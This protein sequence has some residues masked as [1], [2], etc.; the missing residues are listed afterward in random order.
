MR[1]CISVDNGFTTIKSLNPSEPL[2]SDAASNI[3]NSPE[4]SFDA[5]ATLKEVL[6]R[7]SI[8]A[9]NRG[10]LIGMLLLTLARDQVIS[11]ELD[12]CHRGFFNVIDFLKYLF[13][14]GA[15]Q[16]SNFDDILEATPS[17]FQ[18]TAQKTE[19]L[20]DAFAEIY[21]HFN[22]FVKCRA[23][24][25]LDHRLRAG[26]F[27]RNAAVTCANSLPGIDCGLPINRGMQVIQTST[28]FILFQFKNDDSY[29]AAIESHLF[30]MMDPVDLGIITSDEIL[31]VPIIRIVFALA[32]RTPALRYVQ[33]Q[34]EGKFT[35]YDI[36]A[37]G[38]TGRVFSIIGEHI[39]NWQALLDASHGWETIYRSLDKATV[40]IKKTMTPMA[41]R[42]DVFWQWLEPGTAG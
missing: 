6:L 9:G 1:V 31:T 39:E 26:F 35:A 7:Y 14:T 18:N 22:H 37:S 24:S 40:E 17:V 20:R 19:R 29:S 25:H 13:T 10:E 3:M 12:N 38:L 32:G 33:K 34:R 11:Q 16:T 15:S 4:F 23:Q 21:L 5:T 28:A 27:A 2:L 36:W 42:E 41:G 8:H 30:D